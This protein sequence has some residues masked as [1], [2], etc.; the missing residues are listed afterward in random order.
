MDSL[1]PIAAHSDQDSEMI[2]LV[3]FRLFRQI[4]AISI[5][6]LFQIIEMV[7]IVPLPKAESP[8][9][10]VI[11]VR[12]KMTPVLDMRRL[13]HLPVSPYGLHTP[14]LLVKLK[15]QMTGL[16]VDEVINVNAFPANQIAKPADFLPAQ[17]GELTALQG[18]VQ[19]AEGAAMLLDLDHLL[20]PGQELALIHAFEA[21]EKSGSPKPV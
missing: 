16:I 21:L 13:L 4:L 17:L 11:N 10:G 14:I 6:P 2:Q 19:I 3:T 9:E 7:T 18:I 1:P 20:D 12:G 5:E 8:V 15:N